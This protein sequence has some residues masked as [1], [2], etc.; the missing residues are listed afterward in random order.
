MIRFFINL[1]RSINP[2]K[3]IA[4]LT[5]ASGLTVDEVKAGFERET[6]CGKYWNAKAH[7]DPKT[8]VVSIQMKGNERWEVDMNTGKGTRHDWDLDGCCEDTSFNFE[9]SRAEGG[10]LKVTMI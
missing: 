6:H 2:I 9:L 1:I 7:F 5:F 8:C 4:P 3:Q 10:L